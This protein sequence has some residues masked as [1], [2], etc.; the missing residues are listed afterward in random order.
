MF[1]NGRVKGLN[2]TYAKGK[3]YYYHRASGTR[4]SAPFGTAEFYVEFNRID[5]AW[6]GKA[7][8]G[9]T[10]GHL[11][12]E[13]MKT[14]EY[15]RL[16]PR[17]KADYQKI[18]AYM[19]PLKG[20][21]LSQLD[22][23]FVTKLRNKAFS[24]HKRRFSNYVVQVVARVCKIGIGLG[25]LETNP[26]DH[27]EKV[28][29]ATGERHLN[30][31]WTLQER[32]TVLSEASVTLRGP[33]ALMRYLGVRL[34]D[35]RNMRT[36]AYKDGQITFVTGKGGVSVTAPCPAPLAEILDQT[37]MGGDWMFMSGKGGQW[38]EGGFH[39]SLRRLLSRL[40]DEG[41][42][43]SGLTPHGLRHSVATDLRELGYDERA[44]ADILGQKTTYSTPT[45]TRTADMTR[46]NARVL[47]HLYS[48][49]SAK[50][51]AKLGRRSR[52]DI[53]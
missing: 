34:G 33:L 30:R 24:K 27:V 10:W 14:P 9:G 2:K 38:T 37:A 32:D 12:E 3:T 51:S 46:S 47:G 50:P 7:S 1:K 28:R 11:V 8:T 44:I 26:A 13:Y 42:V 41:S 43:G 36:S 17:T 5:K 20:M 16:K 19:E 45:Y 15:Q 49:K 52:V 48:E 22:R 39:A 6:K 29:K 31:P 53:S 35:T 4:I 21:P 23:S 18:F 25:L 40:E